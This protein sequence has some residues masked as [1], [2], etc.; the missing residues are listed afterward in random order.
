MDKLK[1]AFKEERIIKQFQKKKNELVHPLF[2]EKKTKSTITIDIGLLT[3]GHLWLYKLVEE[4]GYSEFLKDIIEYAI[5]K[6]LALFEWEIDDT[7]EKEVSSILVKHNI[8]FSKYLLQDFNIEQYSDIDS[9]AKD[10]DHPYCHLTR[11]LTLAE[12]GM[13]SQIYSAERDLEE[14]LCTPGSVINA[15]YL[16]VTM[17]GREKEITEKVPKWFYEL[18]ERN[19]KCYHEN[20]HFKYYPKMY[21]ILKRL[22][23]VEGKFATNWYL[24]PD[25]DQ[26]IISKLLYSIKIIKELS[27]S[28]FG[29][30]GI[31]SA[32]ST[33]IVFDNYWQTLYLLRNRKVDEYRRFVLDRMRLHILKRDDGSYVN[34]GELLRQVDGGLLDPI[35]VNGD[36]FKKSAREYAIEL[37]IK[38]DYDKYYEYNSE[39]IHAS[40]TAV[41]SG[42]M[43]PCKNPEHDFHLTIKDGGARLIDSVTG[44]FDILNKHIDLINTYYGEESLAKFDI[45]E[46]FF[47]SRDEWT[48]YMNGCCAD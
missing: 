46:M 44:I 34:I 30:N 33:R 18:I 2:A 37:N 27:L 6:K 38:D 43:M 24:I 5:C 13:A 28:L 47:T 4:Y 10:K 31:L 26:V 19:M 1:D 11:L 22:D 15:T 7:V 14:L 32:V 41:Y 16:F 9:K 42:I 40:L 25:D 17:V 12:L 39:F 20:T 45:N 29:L 3:L 23:A 8:A 36:Y 21:E 35:P 48:E